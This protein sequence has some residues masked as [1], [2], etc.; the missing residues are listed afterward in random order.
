MKC[1]WKDQ[2]NKSRKH[3]CH[4]LMIKLT[5]KLS[6]FEFMNVFIHVNQF[7]LL[8]YFPQTTVLMIHYLKMMMMKLTVVWVG[9]LDSTSAG[10]G[11]AGPRHLSRLKS[12]CLASPAHGMLHL[13]V[14]NKFAA[15]HTGFQTNYGR[16][17]KTCKCL[18][19]TS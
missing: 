1:F 9:S 13:L 4:Q 17:Q 5:L 16:W 8:L 3:C 19:A 2:S 10:A 7:T 11:G 15:L 14:L 6:S 12:L 18:W